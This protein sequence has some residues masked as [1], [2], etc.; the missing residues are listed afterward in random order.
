MDIKSEQNE[1]FYLVC[2]ICDE[3]EKIDDN[4]KNKMKFLILLKD[5]I[6]TKVLSEG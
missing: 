1:M 3:I 5:K 2:L 4:I 6:K